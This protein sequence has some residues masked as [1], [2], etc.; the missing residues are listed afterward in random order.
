MTK[1]EYQIESHV[2]TEWIVTCRKE[3]EKVR[4]NI[5]KCN[6]QGI[7]LT[8]KGMYEKYDK[9]MEDKENKLDGDKNNG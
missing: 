9:E 3:G 2:T 7:A 5:A 6:T 8:I 4:E 1:Y